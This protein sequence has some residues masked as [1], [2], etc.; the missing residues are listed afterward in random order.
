[1][2]ETY[3]TSAGN[4]GRNDVGAYRPGS[5]FVPLRQAMDRLFQDSFLAPSLFHNSDFWPSGWSSPSAISGTNLWETNEGYVLQIAMPGMK[6]D[7]IEC[8]VEQNVLT[9][10]G[11]PSVQAPANATA[12]WQSFGGQAGYRIQLPA[13]VESGQAQAT[14]QDGVLTISLPKAVHAR[15]HA[16]KVTAK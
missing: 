15:T 11:Q 4:G 9:C 5:A 13:E 12:L 1:M 10:K 14:Y 2:A 3:R 6:A 8:N 16:I 7:S